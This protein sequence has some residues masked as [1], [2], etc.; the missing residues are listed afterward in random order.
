MPGAVLSLFDVLVAEYEAQGTQ[1]PF[2]RADFEARR[3]QGAPDSELVAG[4]YSWLHANGVR[5]SALC[6]SGGGIRSATFGLGIVQGLARAG[7]LKRFDFLST[8]SGGGYLGSWLSSWIARTRRELAGPQDPRPAVEVVEE[9]LRSRPAS[10]LA[11][12]PEPVRHLRSYSRYMSPRWGLL[13]ADTWTLVAI[14]VRNLLLNWL[15]LLPLLAAALMVPRVSVILVRLGTRPWFQ[16]QAGWLLPAAFWASAA[17]GAVAVAFIGASRSEAEAK[18]PIP[19]GLR[20]QRPFLLLCLMPLYLTAV[21]ISL[22]WAWRRSLPAPPGELSFPGWTLPPAASVVLYAL[23]VYFGGF[24]LA[25][26]WTR[27]PRHGSLLVITASGVLG[28]GAAW[29]AASRLAPRF[30]DRPLTAEL[31]ACF[32]APL[33]LL[34]FLVAVILYVGLSSYYTDDADREWLARA[35]AWVL[36]AVAV[37]GALSTVVIFGPAALVRGA[38]WLSSLGGISGLV[39][40]ILGRGEGGEKGRAE[41]RSEP[42]RGSA[43][44]SLALALAAPLFALFVLTVLSLGTTMLIYGLTNALDPGHVWPSQKGVLPGVALL[45]DVVYGSPWWAVAAV[46]AGL[47]ATGLVMGCFVDVNRFSLHA[48][49]RDRLIRAYLGASRGSRRRPHPFT[50]FDEDDNLEMAELRGNRPFHVVNMTLNLVG[51]KELAWQDRKAEVFTATPLVAGSFRLGYRDVAEYGRGPGGRG[52]L[53]LGTAMAISG[54]AASPNMGSFSSPLVTFLLALFNVRLGWWLGNPGPAGEGTWNTQGPRFAPA[55]L[56]AEAFGLTDDRHPYVYLSDGGHFENLGLYEMVLRRCHFIVVSDGSGDPE[57]SFDDLGNAVS[58]VRV[59]LGVPIRFERILM[60]PRPKNPEAYDLRSGGERGSAQPYCALARIGYSCV[61]RRP[62]GTSGEEMDG[63]L[64]YV[65]PSLNGTE[66]ADVFH[67]AR[68]HPSFPHE[69][70]ADQLYTEQQLESYREL[71][72]HAMSTIL[73]GLPPEASL[74]DLFEKMG[75]ELG[76]PA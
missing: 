57:M 55:S 34:L 63:L 11:P 43:W 47:S 15:V 69:S 25:R 59:D 35:G 45:I 51:G 29:L 75:K 46:L 58:R 49:Y 44:K 5:R 54:A 22:Y 32:A 76:I 73:A 67:Y 68:A 60:R 18:R 12:E 50:G 71:G 8:V 74:A 37:R 64:L 48:A 28:G 10:P 31:Y 26:I 66:P 33:L 61:D 41:A 6:F 39:T 65:K 9:Q 27:R 62:D 53:S 3:Q 70:T 42:G 38:V 1:P 23:L 52:A 21:L 20:G 24:L 19:P 56:L 14:T 40:L 13:S 17:L 72:S 30:L 16:A 2:P 7:L 4:F 36:I